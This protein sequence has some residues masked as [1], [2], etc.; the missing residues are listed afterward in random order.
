ME[1]Y[2]REPKCGAESKLKVRGSRRH[3]FA[4]A[5]FIIFFLLYE[6]IIAPLFGIIPFYILLYSQRQVAS[7][8]RI[9]SHIRILYLIMFKNIIIANQ[10]N[11]VRQNL[12][13]N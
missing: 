3:Y 10:T 4:N 13:I 6:H 5:Q 8:Y 12:L 2:F 11:M 1:L 7:H 9:T